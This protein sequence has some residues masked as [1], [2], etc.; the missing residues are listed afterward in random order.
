TSIAARRFRIWRAN[1]SL[2]IGPARWPV[3]MAL[4]S[5]ESAM[6]RT[7]GAWM[8]WSPRS[9]N[10][11]SPSERTTTANFTCSRPTITRSKG[12]RGESLSWSRSL[13]HPQQLI[14][15]G[16]EQ[17]ADDRADD[18]NPRIREVRTTFA[19]NRQNQVREARCQIARWVDRVTGRSTERQTDAPYE[20]ADQQ[21]A[22]PCTETQFG[23]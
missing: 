5:S 4:C 23:F 1:T 13:L 9:A 6:L 21:R 7:T 15:D 10:M 19:R 14:T 22:E 12:K 11:S 20:R 16:P 8:F 17:A 3:L 2:A 18:G